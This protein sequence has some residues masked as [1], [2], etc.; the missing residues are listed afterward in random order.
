VQAIC[1]I[2]LNANP[3]L[4]PIISRQATV[5]DQTNGLCTS[6]WASGDTVPLGVP[7]KPGTY[8][9]EVWLEDASGNRLQDLLYGFIELTPAGRL[10]NALVN[11]L[12]SQPVLAFGGPPVQSYPSEVN[13]PS[14]L[15]NQG[16]FA[17]ADDIGVLFFANQGFWWNI[18]QV[19]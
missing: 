9:N 2:D 6:P 3:L 16:A 13:F 8:S 10:P 7:V 11:P 4:P 15:A 5:T 1:A 18:G 17:V 12:P 19:S 14:A